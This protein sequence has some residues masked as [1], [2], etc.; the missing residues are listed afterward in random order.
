MTLHEKNIFFI[1]VIGVI[2]KELIGKNYI[3]D[4]LEKLFKESTYDIRREYFYICI[5][6]WVIKDNMRNKKT[7]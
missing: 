3:R 4:I 7:F 5:E 1:F 2:I 6:I